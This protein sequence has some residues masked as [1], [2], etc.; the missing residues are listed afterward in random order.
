[1]A[2][3]LRCSSLDNLFAC[4]PS[5]VA[6]EGDVRVSSAGDEAEVGKAVH[7]LAA[8]FVKGGTFDLK[9]E[10]QRRGVQDEDE[11]ATLIGYACR[12]WEE[13]A[14]FFPKPRTERPV[15]GPILATHTGEFYVTGT[16]DVL[17]G[18]GDADAIFLDWKSGFVDDGYRH[19]MTGYAYCAWNALGRPKDSTITG[20]VAFLRHRYYRIVRYTPAVLEEWEHDLTHNALGSRAYRPG[21]ACEHCAIRHSC[22]AQQA[23][24]GG[25]LTA[26]MV[27]QDTPADDPHRV[28]VE[29]A[30]RLLAGITPENKNDPIV[31]DLMGEMRFRLKLA[32][33]VVEDGEALVR[34]AVERVGNI[35]LP[36]GFELTLR[37][38]DVRTLDPEKAW[39]VLQAHLSTADILAAAR[40]S[41][42]KL[43]AAKTAKVARGAKK[44]AREALEK[45]L[46]AAGAVHVARQR[47]LEEVDLTE[48]TNVPATRNADP[49][50]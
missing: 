43:L 39:K 47:R 11:V 22:A 14:R 36:T 24:V 26:L 17:S 50:E 41:L 15:E 48:T 23:M 30:T 1:M 45:E 37:D 6:D 32:R 5:I 12:A 33:K 3:A 44:G 13:L 29:K 21:R 35:P 16:C 31:R 38:V 7:A 27:P 18:V 8:S 9:G 34:Q 42:P 19:Q 28:F 4:T 10:C 25:T 49:P 40:L 46:E 2:R 20:I